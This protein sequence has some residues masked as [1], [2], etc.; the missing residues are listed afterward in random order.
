MTNEFTMR[1]DPGE[2]PT[3]VHDPI[4]GEGTDDL[5]VRILAAPE[6]S[7]A[8]L[9][10]TDPLLSADEC[11]RFRSRWET[12]QVGFVDDPK[13]AVDQARELVNEVVHEVAQMLDEAQLKLRHDL[14]RGPDTST[15]EQRHAFQR[16]RVFFQ[17]LL[18][19]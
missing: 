6:D 14:Q 10:A 19:V 12:L 4:A 9:A 3:T 18:A 17:R 1:P 13:I 2:R 7:P 5:G 16:Y 11:K 8:R 15:E